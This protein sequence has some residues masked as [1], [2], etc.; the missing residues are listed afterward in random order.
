[1][2]EICFKVDIAPEFKKEFELALTRVVQELI[3]N[4]ELIIAEEIISKS[5][6]TNEDAD[7]LSDKIKLSM[8][9]ALK[10]KGLI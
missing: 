8:H 2:V 4:L 9:N 5:E 6:F 7:E 3:N 10:K 1:M